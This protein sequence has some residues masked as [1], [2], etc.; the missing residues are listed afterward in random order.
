MKKN[1]FLAVVVSGFTLV[2]AI[3]RGY[4]Q[5]Q[6][7]DKTGPRSHRD[8]KAHHPAKRMDDRA[9]GPTLPSHHKRG[10]RMPHHDRHQPDLDAVLELS[11]DQQAKLTSIR[12]V[13]S[14]N[15]VR[16]KA[17]I[18]VARLDLHALIKDD[19]DR[20]EIH[21]QIEAI[22]ILQGEL[23]ILHVDERLDIFETLHHPNIPS[24]E[25]DRMEPMRQ[26]PFQRPGKGPG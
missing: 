5:I 1:V 23:H 12:R 8:V 4:A 10:G 3:D 14:K 9:H 13:V 18:D 21:Q 20:L 7:V 11:P 25:R 2:A 6:D 22:A 17:E 26:R 24:P 16:K 19:S 15:M